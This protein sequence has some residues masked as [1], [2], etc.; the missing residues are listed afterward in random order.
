VAL[1]LKRNGIIRVRPLQGGLNLWMDRK[2][3]TEEL[4]VTRAP[5][6]DLLT[7]ARDQ[8][9]SISEESQAEPSGGLKVDT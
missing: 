2:F 3:P 6:P 7:E 5:C 9:P 1:K 8:L 4:R